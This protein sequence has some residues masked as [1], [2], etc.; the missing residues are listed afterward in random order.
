MNYLRSKRQ[1]ASYAAE[2]IVQMTSAY[3]DSSVENKTAETF[4]GL[5]RTPR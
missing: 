2:R 4:V 1:V 5:R 3:Q